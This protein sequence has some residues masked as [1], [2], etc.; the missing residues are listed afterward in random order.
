MKIDNVTVRQD[1]K[2]TLEIN[3]IDGES[4]RDATGSLIRDRITSKHKLNIEWKALKKQEANT[5]LNQIEGKGS[6]SVQFFSPFANR[7]IT[8]TM[9]AGNRSIE[10]YSLNPNI[11]L[12]DISVNFIEV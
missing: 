10:Y 2:R 8:L 7:E 3:D 6:F 12:V 9:Y 11:Q 1:T 4:H 5:I